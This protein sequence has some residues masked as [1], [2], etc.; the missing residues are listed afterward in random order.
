MEILHDSLTD[1]YG[2][3]R[4]SLLTILPFHIVYLY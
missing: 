4:L 2:S 1:Y 3:F